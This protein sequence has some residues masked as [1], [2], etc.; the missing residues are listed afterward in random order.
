MFIGFLFINF[1]EFLIYAFY[2]AY[3]LIFTGF[4]LDFAFL[5]ENHLTHFFHVIF[6]HFHFGFIFPRQF[7]SV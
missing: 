4:T 5:F 7:I 2:R 3:I 1:F 6:K